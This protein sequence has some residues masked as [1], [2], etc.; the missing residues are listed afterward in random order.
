MNELNQRVY[1][2]A[3]MHNACE[4]SLMIIPSLTTEGLLEL[5]MDKIDYSLCSDFLNAG[6]L[7]NNA[8]KDQLND[9]GIFVNEASVVRVDE[10]KSVFIGKTNGCV[11][12]T[13]FSSVQ[14]FIKDNSLID[15]D[16]IENSFT[17]I[18]C[19]D[20]S[21]LHIIA[22]DNAN[23]YVSIYGQSQVTY[24]SHN[25]SKVKLVYKNTDKY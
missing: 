20:N 16:A 24:E 15:L 2:L 11:M 18:D 5:F 13:E 8:T 1:D 19:F 7:K 14:L 10:P 22:K 17:V 23:V 12:S 25:K 9:A 3:K 6:F 4:P 21:R